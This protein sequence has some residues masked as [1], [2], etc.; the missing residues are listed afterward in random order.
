MIEAIAQNV[1]RE[2]P[3][4]WLKRV[5]APQPNVFV[6]K[7]LRSILSLTFLNNGKP[8]PKIIG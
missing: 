5:T 3:V 1:S 6:F 2:G 7:S 4:T 8:L